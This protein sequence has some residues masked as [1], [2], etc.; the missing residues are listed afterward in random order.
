MR[1]GGISS[2]AWD[3]GDGTVSSGVNASHV[4]SAGGTFNATLKVTDTNGF[5]ASVMHPVSISKPVNHQK[6]CRRH[7]RRCK[8]RH[9]RGH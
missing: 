2:Y 8:R 6:K 1:A 5:S 3:F 7:K 9:K 4:Y